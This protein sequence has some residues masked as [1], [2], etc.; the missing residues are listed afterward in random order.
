M[1][2]LYLPVMVALF[3]NSLQLVHVTHTLV[4]L[5]KPVLQHSKASSQY[6]FC[7]YK[8]ALCGH[9]CVTATSAEVWARVVLTEWFVNG[10]TYR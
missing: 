1:S 5:I 6:C 2:L 8:I 7:A 9:I 10:R 4:S 3:H